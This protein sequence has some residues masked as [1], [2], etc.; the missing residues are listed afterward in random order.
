[1]GRQDP[2]VGR[3]RRQ[4]GLADAQGH[5]HRM[6]DVQGLVKGQSAQAVRVE[7]VGRKKRLCTQERGLEK[8]RR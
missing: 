1:M 4:G 6:A 2:V 8:K 3:E 5:R 7:L